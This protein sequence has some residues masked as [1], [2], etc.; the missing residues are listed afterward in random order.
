MYVHCINILRIN[1][2]A[3]V[4]F[5]A[6]TFSPMSI[7]ALGSQVNEFASFDNTTGA[8]SRL[9]S[10]HSVA[11]LSFKFVP[12]FKSQNLLTTFHVSLIVFFFFCY[13]RVGTK[14]D[15]AGLAWCLQSMGRS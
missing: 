1:G 14:V 9:N 7:S 8:R 15:T 6:S 4:R 10:A 13:E 11:S 2:F 5:I 12:S 3:S